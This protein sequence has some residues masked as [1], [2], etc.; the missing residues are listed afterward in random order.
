MHRAIWIG[1]SWSM[2]D[3]DILTRQIKFRENEKKSLHIA[4]K[5]LLAKIRSMEWLSGKSPVTENRLK[6]AKSVDELRGIEAAHAKRYWVKYYL[7]LGFKRPERRNRNNDVSATLNAVS[8]FVSGIMMRYIIFHKMSVYHGFLHQPVSYPAL[9]YDLVEP[10]RGH[11]DKCVFDALHE[12]HDDHMERDKMVS[13]CIN[14]V[15]DL[16][17]KNVYT[18]QTRQV[19]T[20]Q[21]LLHGS[22]LALRAYLIGEASRY[23][24]PI[25]GRPSGGRPLQTGYRLYGRQA[26]PMNFYQEADKIADDWNLEVDRGQ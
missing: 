20:F 15:K 3:K 9:I 6:S 19:V 2:S 7:A 25:P 16:M 12:V 21:E 11:I 22:V 26:G 13:C 24:V 4:R 5:I 17:N 23:I 18:H 14:A 10:Y 1:G 8:K